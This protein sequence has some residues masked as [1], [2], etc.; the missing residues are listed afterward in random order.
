M[1]SF[2]SGTAIASHF[3]MVREECQFQSL[4]FYLPRVT[5]CVCGGEP[6][7]RGKKLREKPWLLAKAK[8]IRTLQWLTKAQ[9][10]AAL[11]IKLESGGA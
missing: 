2:I 4:I 8:T 11:A 3:Y 10:G 1:N 7:V 5:S 6:P 9:Q